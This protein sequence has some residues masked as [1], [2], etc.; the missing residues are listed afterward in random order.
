MMKIIFVLLLFSSSV[1]SSTYMGLSYGLQTY[2]SEA[3][4]KYKVTPKGMSYGGFIGIGRDFVGLEGFY[5]NLE[6]KGKVKHDGEKYDINANAQAY[7]A[8]LRFSFEMFYLRLGVAQ[9]KL[10][11]SLKID[12]DSTRRAAEKV[13]DIQNGSKNGMLY[14]VGLHRKI[15]GIKVFLDYSRYQIT[16]VGAYDTISGGFAFVIPDRFFDVGKN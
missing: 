4:D 3:L 8:A 2:G 10:D 9:Y 11:Q 16:G 15:G 7:G 14:G 1:F 5:Q 13:Y 6:T 12:D